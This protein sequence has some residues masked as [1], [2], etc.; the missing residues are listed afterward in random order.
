MA[1][2]IVLYRSHKRL[3]KPQEAGTELVGVGKLIKIVL[4]LPDLLV[5]PTLRPTMTSSLLFPI[6]RQPM[7]FLGFEVGADMRTRVKAGA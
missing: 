7:S 5:G 3:A 2:F 1:T 6:P 4:D